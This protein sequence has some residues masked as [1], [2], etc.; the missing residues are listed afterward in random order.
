MRELR[1]LHV[2]ESLGRAGAEQ[3]L[4]NVLPV[5]VLD[6]H[7]VDVAALWGP[8]PLAEALESKGVRVYRLD[9][10]HRWNVVEGVARLQSLIQRERYDVLHAHSFFSAMYVALTRPLSPRPRRVVTFHNLGYDSF[11]ANTTWRRARKRIDASLMRHGVDVRLAVSG[12]TARHYEHHL[13]LPP[14]DVQYNAIAV[15]AQS[16]ADGS[17]VAPSLMFCGRLVHEK[18]HRYFLEALTTLKARGV[19]PPAMIVGDGPLQSEIA[20]DIA[21]RELGS[22]VTMRPA[23]PHD[24]M[25]A[26]MRRAQIVVMAST[27]EGFPLTPAEAMALG[28]P[29]IATRVGGLPE[30][31]EDGVEGLLV[32]PKDPGALADAIERLLGD[33]HLRSRFGDKG[34]ARITASFSDRAVAAQLTNRYRRAIDP[35]GASPESA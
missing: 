35:P 27:H 19:S 22:Q 33:P 4:V 34:K 8:Y 3:A 30:L 10:S 6:G 21:R 18:G 9:L 11:P 7:R 32:P 16:I 20:A 2:I 13:Q 24:E 26:L 31:I 25:I 5:L 28:I 15:P 23:V 14:I 29:V 12:A 1:I 17:S